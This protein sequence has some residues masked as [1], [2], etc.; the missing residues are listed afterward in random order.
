MKLKNRFVVATLLTLSGTSLSL[1]QFK[2]NVERDAQLLQKLEGA[3]EG[4]AETVSGQTIV[5]PRLRQDCPEA[6][7]TR[8]TTGTMAIE[9]KSQAVPFALRAKEVTFVVMAGIMTRPNTSFKFHLFINDTS[10]LVF[11][12]TDTVSWEAGVAGGARI[13]F[14]GVMQDQYTDAFGYML[15][16]VP[17][18]LA[19]PGEQ[20]RFKVVGDSAGSEVWF[21]VFKDADVVPFLK[22]KADNEAYCDLSIEARA[23]KQRATLVVPTSWRGKKISYALGENPAS[24]LALQSRND[25]VEAIFGL[26]A[27]KNERF[28]LLVNG[29]QIIDIKGL[30]NEINESRLI[31]KRLV[32]LRSRTDLSG[33]WV[34]EYQSMYAPRSD[35]SLVQLSELKKGGK[36]DLIISTHQ[37]IAWMD[38]PEQCVKDRDE[39][40]L[41]PALA[42]MK[43]DSSYRFDL[44]DVLFLREYLDRHPDRKAD[45]QKFISEGRLGIGASYNQP[46]EDLSSGEMLVREF[47]AGR[48]WLRKNFP[49]CDTHTYWNADVPGRSAQMP[50]ILHRAGVKY[51][52]ISRFGKG[53]YNWLS[54]DGSGV[55][56]MSPGHYGDFAERTGN[57]AI[58]DIA[59]YLASFAHD[60]SG[61]IK[62]GSK[63]VPVVSM[64][65][66]STP[67]RYV[68]FME[69][70]NGLKSIAL[71]GTGARPLTLP[72]IHYSTAEQ[73]FDAA[74]AEN[75]Q[76]PSIQGER[77]NIWLYIHGPTHHW[78]ISAK[79]EADISLPA[80]ETFSTIDALLRKSFALY[81]QNELTSAWESQL[82]PDHGW[83][84]KNGEITDSTFRAKYE[85]A[86]DLGKRICSQATGSIAT[87]IRTSSNKG[88]PLVVFNGLSWRR[89]A[90]V[91]FAASFP[92]SAFGRGFTLHDASGRTL[93]SQILSAERYPNGSIRS[94]EVVF[95]AE[96]VPPVGYETFYLR[97][98]SLPVIP[99]TTSSS[100]QVLLNRYYRIILGQGGVRQIVDVELQKELLNTDKFLGGELFTMQSVGEDAGEWSEPQQPTM[101]GFDKLSNYKP[102]WQLVESGPVRQVA[103]M[104]QDIAHATVVQRIILYNYLKQIDFETSLLKW[105]GTKYREFRLA[106][107]VNME[108]G[109]VAYE[110][111]FGA[112]EV[113]N[114]E[115]K[116]TAGERYQR[117]VSTLHPRSVQNW[118]SVS[119]DSLGVTISSSVAVWDYQDPTDRPSRSPL[120][121]PILLASRKSC[122]GLGP[123]YLQAG[124]HFY[125]FSLTSHRSGWRNGRHF[126]V[127]A[128]APLM[129]VFNPAA[130]AKPNLPEQRSFFSVSAE[131]V[132]LST[133]KKCEDDN[134]VVVRL[135]EDAGK[136]VAARLRFVTP[137]QGVEI[138]NIIEEEG[139]PT[140]FKIDEIAF[141]LTH[142]SIQTFKVIPKW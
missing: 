109:Q 104:R 64:S 111:P 2:A 92:Q 56:A 119:D 82:Y 116:G 141:A 138:T 70:W 36:L 72:P 66:M 126:G 102:N 3:L 87:R 58:P 107:P 137:M 33:H 42:I 96:D 88:T 62:N 140:P 98:S 73:F 38:S 106:F 17:A 21:M 51:M 99:D 31:P 90:P 4:Y 86:R 83:G 80:A 54:P 8:A 16:H 32:S 76:L 34:L 46:Y 108:Q 69:K 122:H 129:V 14:Y 67:T 27:K 95:I 50:Q 77:P 48:K 103:E 133:I 123:W 39:K 59:G 125:R 7:I 61:V 28:R 128:N 75:L 24:E 101:E 65:D 114:D 79:R 26:E 43:D 110:V 132:V 22:E 124:D 120:L 112:V 74:S 55:L 15:I 115:M 23:K 81:P 1:S 10:N 37:D 139:K 44:E 121:Q 35:T 113:G 84:G 25:S 49:G 11:T 40:I 68:E 60:W 117:E 63:N 136:D 5:Y 18:D 89:T 78:A 20:V 94:A 12:T 53:L 9:W 13:S 93:S 142:E 130:S 41:T 30:F 131:N 6:L 45:L 91:Q 19:T 47:Y 127:A 105:D 135:Y 134:N 52:F 118:I 57:K 29:E 71:P 85:F 100:I 97:P